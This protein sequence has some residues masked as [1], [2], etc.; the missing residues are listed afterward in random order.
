MQSLKNMILSIAISIFIV[1]LLFGALNIIPEFSL[2]TPD[3]SKGCAWRSVPFDANAD[4]IISYTDV[5]S[6]LSGIYSNFQK[7]LIAFLSDSFI[8][9]FLEIRKNSCINIKSQV[10]N[11]IFFVL[12]SV[13]LS[14]CV[15]SIIKLVTP[16]FSVASAKNTN[17]TSVSYINKNKSAIDAIWSAHLKIMLFIIIIIFLAINIGN[18]K[19]MPA[20]QMP[21]KDA[22]TNKAKPKERKTLTDEAKSIESGKKE[23]AAKEEEQQRL[24]AK[25][26]RDRSDAA[27]Q[28]ALKATQLQKQIAAKE[29]QDRNEIARTEAIKAAQLRQEQM[30]LEERRRQEQAA[31]SE[32][33]RIQSIRRRYEARCNLDL[34]NAREQSKARYQAECDNA[35]GNAKN[36]G[37]NRFAATLCYVSVGSKSE[38]YAKTVFDACMSGAPN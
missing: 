1:G 25:E 19:E 22:A 8:G 16:L 6:W 14:R 12:A 7:I 15:L 30:A 38:E 21:Q 11:F 13:G 37:V 36:T 24:A 35:W 26:E 17:S 9:R 34:V 31:A 4:G 10:I 33:A 32:Q 3:I 20:S 18:R 5:F 28:E 29:E 27:N 2:V 23:L